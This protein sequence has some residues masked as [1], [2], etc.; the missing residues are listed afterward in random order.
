[1]PDSII[2]GIRLFF[3]KTVLYNAVDFWLIRMKPRF[4]MNESKIFLT[5]IL[6]NI[7]F[8]K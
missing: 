6:F 3:V 1:M 4:H 5:T 2:L 8:V 7:A